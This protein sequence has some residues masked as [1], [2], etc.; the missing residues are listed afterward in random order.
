MPELYPLITVIHGSVAMAFHTP[1][2][3]SAT[4]ISPAPALPSTHC[5]LGSIESSY[6]RCVTYAISEPIVIIPV[7]ISPA[8][9][10]GA[11]MNFTVPL[12]LPELPS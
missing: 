7:R 11:T 9:I 6:G 2:M 5:P 1:A 3:S 4:W 8:P 10:Y 12:P